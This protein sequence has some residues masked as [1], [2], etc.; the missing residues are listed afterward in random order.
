MSIDPLHCKIE[1]LR[2]VVEGLLV[3][4]HFT[5]L[6][7][8]WS[9]GV[10]ERPGKE[11]L[12]VFRAFTSELQMRSQEWS[13]LLSFVESVIENATSPQRA[14]TSSIKAMTGMD[15][16]SPIS[17]FY[18]KINSV[19]TTITRV[20]QHR[21][22]NIEYLTELVDSLHPIVQNAFQE[23]RQRIRDQAS[24]GK[25]S[26][27]NE[28]DFVLVAREDFHAGEKLC[29]R[30]RGLRRVVRTVNDYVYQM[31]DVCNGAI[32][33]VHVSRLRFYHETLLDCEAIMSHVLI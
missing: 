18:R 33:D 23:N 21:A 32:D 16:S 27:F 14:G 10:V 13:D 26:N 29:L 24:N 3:P 4:H 8:P 20:A 19:P 31:E 11:L 1:T 6:Y 22:I 7:T 2:P 5:L 30:W 9:S 17:T 28:G 12:R 15:A 25:L